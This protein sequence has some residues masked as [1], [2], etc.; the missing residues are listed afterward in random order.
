MNMTEDTAIE[1]DSNEVVE[2]NTTYNEN[3]EVDYITE[4][5][6]VSKNAANRDVSIEKIEST[7]G[8]KVEGDYGSHL[9]RDS[10]I[11]ISGPPEKIE[12]F[13]SSIHGH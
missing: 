1:E 3:M 12:I 2:E 13:K 6:H 5:V 11:T 9:K 10:I 4:D 7:Y 8:I